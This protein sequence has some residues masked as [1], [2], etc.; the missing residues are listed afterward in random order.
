M[1]S[2]CQTVIKETINEQNSKLLLDKVVC[3]KQ[4]GLNLLKRKL[5]TKVKG[6]NSLYYYIGFLYK[7]ILIF[8]ASLIVISTTCN[9]DLSYKFLIENSPGGVLPYMVLV[10]DVAVIVCNMCS[11]LFDAISS[12]YL[13]FVIG[14]DSFKNLTKILSILLCSEKEVKIFS[15]S[16]AMLES[17]KYLITSDKQLLNLA[18]ILLWWV[19]AWSPVDFLKVSTLIS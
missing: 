6:N 12:N 19:L 9:I 2:K 7:V 18:T 11:Y 4:M 16:G 10:K 8:L 14:Q 5:P 15:V 3:V 1:C 13:P 17:V